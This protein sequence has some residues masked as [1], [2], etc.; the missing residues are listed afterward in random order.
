MRGA[1]FR[2]G[3]DDAVPGWTLTGKLPSRV[4]CCQTGF[5]VDVH[6]MSDQT[7][8]TTLFVLFQNS[9]NFSSCQRNY[10]IGSE[11]AT[12]GLRTLD[13]FFNE[14][15]SAGA[16]QRLKFYDGYLHVSYEIFINRI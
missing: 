6:L 11:T 8:A 14:R 13:E 4:A 15:K 9:F 2:R 10:F 5:E 7:N 1:K 12:F 3:C 16:V